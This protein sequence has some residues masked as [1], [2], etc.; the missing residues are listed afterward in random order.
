MTDRTVP[1]TGGD[2][3]VPREKMEAFG[4]KP[5]SEVELRAIIDLAPREFPPEEIE[6]RHAILAE[7]WGSWSAEDEAAYHRNRELWSK[8]EPRK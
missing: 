7:L 8:W 1:Y 5:G 3:V 6:R 2:L 4:I